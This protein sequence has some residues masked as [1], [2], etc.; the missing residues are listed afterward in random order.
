MGIFLRPPPRLR[1]R[2]LRSYLSET[3]ERFH[4]PQPRQPRPRWQDWP[5]CWKDDSEPAVGLRPDRVKPAP[6]CQVGGSAERAAA[7]RVAHY[8]G[9]LV[10]ISLS[11]PA[12][13][14]KRRRSRFG[15]RLIYG[16]AS[17]S[18][19]SVSPRT[20]SLV[21]GCEARATAVC[22]ESHCICLS[23]PRTSGL[24]DGFQRSRSFRSIRRSTPGRMQ[25]SSGFGSAGGQEG[26][27]EHQC[28]DC[29]SP[30]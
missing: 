24:R 19:G 28:P 27:L 21:W 11:E 18:E 5:G 9:L 29:R 22:C 3:S 7:I 1:A 25:P 6:G 8:A 14:L 15:K 4:D 17:S 26:L 12:L 23:F 16:M 13:R 10:T 2:A 20:V 30:L